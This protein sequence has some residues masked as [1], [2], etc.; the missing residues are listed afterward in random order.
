MGEGEEGGRGGRGGGAG[1]EG[2]ERK[3]GR[4]ERGETKERK[5]DQPKDSTGFSQPSTYI[6]LFIK[7]I[8]IDRKTG[9]MILKK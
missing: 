8:K 3:G 1:E 4:E 7:K 6:T 5:K 9:Q 2:R